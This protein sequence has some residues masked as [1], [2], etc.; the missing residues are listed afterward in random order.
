MLIQNIVIGDGFDL[1]LLGVKMWKDQDMSKL[2][3]LYAL[4]RNLMSYHL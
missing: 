1:P 2:F 4:L 3:D